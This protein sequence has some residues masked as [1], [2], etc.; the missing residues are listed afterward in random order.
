MTPHTAALATYAATFDVVCPGGK[1]VTATFFTTEGDHIDGKPHCIWHIKPQTGLKGL[2]AT[3]LKDGT[4]FIQ[5][6]V[7]GIHVTRV[8]PGNTHPVLCNSQTT[9]AGKYEILTVFSG[10]NESGGAT[11][12]SL[13]D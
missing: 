5:G 3:D 1:E 12:I 8:S 9:N 11:S 2:H 13:S 7:E 6:E 4:V 10:L